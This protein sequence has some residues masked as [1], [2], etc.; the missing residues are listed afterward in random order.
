MVWE[1]IYLF[2]VSVILIAAPIIDWS[3]TYVLHKASRKATTRSFALEERSRV[4]F[5]LALSN[6]ISGFLAACR[7][8]AI[9]LGPTFIILLGISLTLSSV[10]NAYWLYSYLRNK[11][12]RSGVA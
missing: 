2:I 12:R 6:T 11:F 5:I 8:L 7:L 3:A 10:P 1:D 4:A 9:V